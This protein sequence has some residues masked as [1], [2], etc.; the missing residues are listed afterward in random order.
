MTLRSHNRIQAISHRTGMVLWVSASAG[1]AGVI[2]NTVTLTGRGYDLMRFWS[3]PEQP[4]VT[5]QLTR[6]L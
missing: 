3:K 6:Q 1:C 5:D 2:V 4:I